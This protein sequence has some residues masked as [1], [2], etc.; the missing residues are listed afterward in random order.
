MNRRL[1]KL[2]DL[3]SQNDFDG[4][5]ISKPANVTY[6]TGFTGDESVAIVTRDKAFFITDSRYIEQAKIETDGFL[7]IDNNRDMLKAV[8][9]CVNLS[10]I[11]KLGFEGGYMT[12]ETYAILKETYRI[13][14]EPLNNIIEP[15]RSIKDE[16]EIENIKHAQK[17]AEKAFEH[18]LGIIKVGMKEKDIAAEME[19]YMRKEG[20]EGTSFDTIVA[21]GFRSA[22]PHGKASEKTIKNGEFVVFDYGCKYNG[23][24]S[25]MTRTIVV[26]KA[27]E[28]QKKIYN[29]V[30]NAQKHALENL[31]ANIKEYEGDNLARSV[32]EN[33][34]YGEYF[35]HSLGH[36]VGLEIHESPYM[37]K[38]KNGTL[39]IN[40]VV[41]VEPGIY[42]PNFGGVRIED[43][44][45]IEENGVINLTDS[46]KELIEI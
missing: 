42:I 39:K 22:L 19:Y 9:E 6:I 24:C 20:A 30:L 44:V 1:M 26:G 34:G 10:G 29:I 5:Y 14:L 43:M 21:S 46:P 11:K 7:I 18:I 8:S 38:N 12:Y 4:Y 17:I 23:Y 36:G 13:H 35:G 32:I 31:K 27:T 37:A 3:L 45:V 2:Q 40:M 33:E 15:L 28:E 16:R 41:T 25:D